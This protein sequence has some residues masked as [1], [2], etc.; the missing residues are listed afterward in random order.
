VSILKLKTVL[1]ELIE[2][3]EP[4]ASGDIVD[5]TSGTIPL[6]NRLERAIDRAG[7]LLANNV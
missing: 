3:A 1:E 6:M 4:F 2:A 7:E 5:E